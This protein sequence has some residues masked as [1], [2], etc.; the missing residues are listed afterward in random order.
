VVEEECTSSG[1]LRADAEIGA[2]LRALEGGDKALAET[3][4]TFSFGEGGERPEPEARVFEMTLRVLEGGDRAVA[5][6]AGTLSFL[7][8]GESED[9]KGR[10]FWTTLRALDGGVRNLGGRA[11]T[12]RRAGRLKLEVSTYLSDATSVASGMLSSSRIRACVSR[13][14]RQRGILCPVTRPFRSGCV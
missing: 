6:M 7:E 11:T 13:G 9:P 2:V 14:K 3:A 1:G 4:G 8:G 5:E 12:A 10:V